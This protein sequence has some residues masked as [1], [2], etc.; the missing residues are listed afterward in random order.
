M[1]DIVRHLEDALRRRRGAQQLVLRGLERGDLDVRGAARPATTSSTTTPRS[2]CCT[3][4]PAVKV[5]G[6]A[7]SGG[8]SPNA[9]PRLIDFVADASR[10]LKLDFVSYHHYGQDSAA[11]TRTRAASSTSSRSLMTL[12]AEQELHRRASSTTSGA[13][14]T[15]R[16]CRATPRRRPA[17]SPSRSTSSAPTRRRACRTM[18]GYWTLSDIYEEMNTGTGARLPGGELRPAAEGRPE[19]P[20]VV[21]CR[22]AGV[23]RAS[24]CCT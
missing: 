11:R 1:A 20:R 3:G 7:D 6:P 13:P 15:T 5:G 24:A 23:Q 2:A 16:S 9:I 17:S 19:H 10:G 22:Q 18:Y 12:I 14:A 8:N 4:D 21:R